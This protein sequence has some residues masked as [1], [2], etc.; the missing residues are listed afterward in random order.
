MGQ[1]VNPIIFRIGQTTTWP[2]SWFARKDV[3]PKLLKQ[4]I[5]IRDFLLN[6]LKEAGLDKIEIQRSA[7]NITLTIYAAKPGFIIGKGGTGIEELKK[8]IKAKFLKNENLII[9]IQE[10]EK[11][12]LSARVV[13]TSIIADLEKRIPFRRVLKHALDRIE[14]AGA[15]GA[16]VR[17]SG[18]LDGVEIARSETLSFGTL[19]LHNLRAE[20]DYAFGEAKTIYGKIGVK[21]WIYRGEVFN[22][23]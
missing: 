9:N 21:V 8:L 17:V 1:K 6:H 12:F 19:P 11:P 23:K 18:R 13:L 5:E 15:K 14:K 22:K 16:K 3:Y 7:N 4:D 10:I 20:I 2:S